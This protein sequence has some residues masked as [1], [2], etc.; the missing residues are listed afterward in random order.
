LAGLKNAPIDCFRRLGISF[1]AENHSVFDIP[2]N[3]DDNDL[4]SLE[5]MRLSS[6]IKTPTMTILNQVREVFADFNLRG[7]LF[8]DLFPARLGDVD[9]DSFSVPRITIEHCLLGTLH[10]LQ[11]ICWDMSL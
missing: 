8:R 10:H 11:R 6:V 1:K 5:Q 9:A 3:L 2:F 4:E 7:Q